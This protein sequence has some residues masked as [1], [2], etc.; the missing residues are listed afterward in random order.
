MWWGDCCARR[1]WTSYNIFGSFCQRE[2]GE[3]HP[4]TGSILIYQS[5]SIRINI[6]TCQHFQLLLSSHGN[7]APGYLNIDSKR[8]TQPLQ[9]QLDNRPQQDFESLPIQEWTLLIWSY[10]IIWINRYKSSLRILPTVKITLRKVK[11]LESG[12]IRL[13][14]PP[15]HC[16][17]TCAIHAVPVSQSA[18]GAICLARCFR[19]PLAPAPSWG[20]RW[21]PPSAIPKAAAGTSGWLN[22]DLTPRLP[23]I[24]QGSYTC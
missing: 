13:K 1:P 11:S 10:K 23:D 3:R 17:V 8:S 4:R 14:S 7:F 12:L 20:L 22:K 24:I 9:T 18:G 15:A 21:L 2:V 19:K 6:N 5:H 16:D